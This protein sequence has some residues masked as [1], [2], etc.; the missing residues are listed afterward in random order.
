[1]SHPLRTLRRTH[2]MA[3]ALLCACTMTA[4]ASH[5]FRRASSQTA[6]NLTGP[7]GSEAQLAQQ[8]D[9][10]LAAPEAQ[11]STISLLVTNGEEVVYSRGA[12][13]R[14]MAASNLKL[15]TTAAALN[16]LGEDYR[17]RTE[18]LI[19]GRVRHGVLIGNLYLRG[20]GDPTI[21]ANGYAKLAEQVRASGIEKIRGALVFDDTWFE[22]TQLNPG[23]E[24]GDEPSHDAAPISALTM[25]VN[26]EYQISS[27]EL[28]I[29]PG[30]S[31]GA[32]AQVTVRPTR[33]T[34]ELT[35]RTT[36]LS[37]GSNAITV[38]REHGTNRIVVSGSVASRVNYYLAVPDSTAYVAAWFRQMLRQAGVKHM[39]V[40]QT[41]I[42]TPAGARPVA[43]QT[44]MPLRQLLVYTMKL[45]NN[46][47]AEILIKSLG[48]EKAG[49]GSWSAG[50]Q[51]VAKFL[52]ANGIDS[53]GV[54]QVDGSGLSRHN[55]VQ[56][57]IVAQL[58]SLARRKPWF[59]TFFDA[60]PLA[61]DPE[62]LVGGTLSARMQGT[63]AAGNLRA[64]TGTLSGVSGLSGYV[65]SRD[66]KSLIF[67][68]LSDNFLVPA[69]QFNSAVTD[70]IAVALAS[71]CS[72][73]ECAAPINAGDFSNDQTRQWHMTAGSVERDGGG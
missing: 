9:Q 52:D 18:V 42:H 26:D 5:L 20:S 57:G 12:D 64:K 15:L 35:N 34:L 69:K 7:K 49:T 44:S 14:H 13:A 70:K 17:F 30:S 1:M 54:A 2:A 45:S 3:L 33:A 16:E 23:W 29:G 24:I 68:I 22:A 10:I 47:Q 53:K 50:C 67:S 25:A 59:Q 32:P 56:V 21:D 62:K 31:P 46:A 60:L 55:F 61:G 73:G 6:E 65:T 27:F 36:T 28:D 19:D 43:E 39:G 58:L 4:C 37:Q 71:W 40:V 41:G 11:G 8:I 66:G 72:A 51:A 63:P 38:N 48:A